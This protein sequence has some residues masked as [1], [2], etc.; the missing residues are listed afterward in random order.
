MDP[1]PAFASEQAVQAMSTCQDAGWNGEP[2]RR[3]CAGS[4]GVPMRIQLDMYALHGV[5]RLIAPSMA[6]SGGD[7]SPG[8]QIL[9]AKSILPAETGASRSLPL[10]SE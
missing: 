6:R 7:I 8:N 9:P 2:A 1:E 3:R 4:G 10:P 5:S